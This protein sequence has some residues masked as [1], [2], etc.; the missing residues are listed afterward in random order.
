MRL[1]RL[2]VA[3]AA[4]HSQHGGF[5]SAAARGA[6]SGFGLPTLNVATVFVCFIV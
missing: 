2:V 5:D 3:R 6:G 1:T 4:L